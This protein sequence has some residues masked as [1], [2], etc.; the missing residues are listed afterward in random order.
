MCGGSPVRDILQI[1]RQ[2]PLASE[3]APAPRETLQV[4]PSAQA[5]CP[6]C[7]TPVQSSFT[8]CPTCGAALKSQ[9]CVYCGHSLSPEDAAC[10]ACGAPRP[11]KSV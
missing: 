9:P 7:R 1:V 6:S 5:Y 4:V 10:P 8:W 2:K 3:R 11:R